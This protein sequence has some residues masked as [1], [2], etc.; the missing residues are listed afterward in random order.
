MT[1]SSSQESISFGALK[2]L[3]EKAQQKPLDPDGT[4]TIDGF[5]W[6]VLRL[7]LPIAPSERREALPGIA[8]SILMAA[9]YYRSKGA[10]EAHEVI[11]LRDG[12]AN[13]L[14]APAVVLAAAEG[15]TSDAMKVFRRSK[16]I[17]YLS[18]THWPKTWPKSGAPEG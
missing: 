5:E 1:E 11:K 18:P 9:V 12:D 14:I 3:L 10:V 2:V 13:A 16:H 7:L 8:P 6:R 4:K 17:D 15:F